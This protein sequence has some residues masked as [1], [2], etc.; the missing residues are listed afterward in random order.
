MSGWVDGGCHCGS[1]RFRVRGPIDHAVVCNCSICDKKGLLH[2]IVPPERF[3]LLTERDALTTYTFN[4]GV[5]QH[6][7]CSRCGVHP[8]YVPR[9]HPDKIDVNLRCLEAVDVAALPLRSFD[10]RNW[11]QH[12]ERLRQGL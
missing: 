12:V 4:T 8:F 5:A 10:G 9:S 3:E 11:E 2:F 7:F 1:V 6:T